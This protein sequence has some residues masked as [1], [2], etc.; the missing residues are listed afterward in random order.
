MTGCLDGLAS[1][2]SSSYVSTLPVAQSSITST[3]S[4]STSVVTAVTC[5]DGQYSVTTG[6]SQMSDFILL[7]SLNFFCL[8]FS[9]YVLLY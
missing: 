3:A 6:V 8:P 1:W 9:F 7:S 5:G 4:F 2:L